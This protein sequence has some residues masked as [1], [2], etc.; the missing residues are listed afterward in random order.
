MLFFF[1]ECVLMF[2]DFKQMRCEFTVEDSDLTNK[3]TL[4]KRRIMNLYNQSGVNLFDTEDSFFND[5]CSNFSSFNDSA[6]DVTLKDR[7]ELYWRK[8]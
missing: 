4:S 6:R 5:K 1:L 7:R 2:I 3:L 8:S